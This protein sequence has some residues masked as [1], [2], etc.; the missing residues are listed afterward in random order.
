MSYTTTVTTTITVDIPPGGPKTPFVAK[1]GL[2]LTGYHGER[3][4]VI[5]DPVI[6]NTPKRII[7]LLTAISQ[8][9]KYI[10]ETGKKI[11]VDPPLVILTGYPLDKKNK[12]V[13]LLIKMPNRAEPIVNVTDQLTM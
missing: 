11:L 4:L 8:K 2:G 7:T 1:R 6:Y 10:W 5:K 9:K 12:L 13:D 3:I